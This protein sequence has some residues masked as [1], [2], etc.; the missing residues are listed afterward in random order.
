MSGLWA[1]VHCGTEH[2]L[3]PVEEFCECGMNRTSQCCEKETAA[4]VIKGSDASKG[5]HVMR[6]R[7]EGRKETTIQAD[8]Y[9]R[10]I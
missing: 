4:E 5:G 7:K 10:C 6:F 3:V 1:E 9:S 2:S 8:S